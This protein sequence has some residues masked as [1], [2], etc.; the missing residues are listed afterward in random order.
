[1]I[2]QENGGQFL[3]VNSCPHYFGSECR[4]RT[5]ALPLDYTLPSQT[6]EYV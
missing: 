3:A 6:V 2:Q 4:A 5:F 1:M